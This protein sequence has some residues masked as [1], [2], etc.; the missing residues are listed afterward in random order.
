MNFFRLPFFATHLGSCALYR[1]W[2]GGRWVNVW[3][4]AC[5]P[6]AWLPQSI[7]LPPT[8]VGTPIIEDWTHHDH[9][10]R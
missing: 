9:R 10:T 7:P 2:Y 8:V 4:S 5:G 1:K 6:N 3:V